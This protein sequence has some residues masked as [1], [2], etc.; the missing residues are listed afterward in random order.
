MLMSSHTSTYAYWLGLSDMRQEGTWEWQSS[1]T[2]ASYVNWFPENPHHD[3][4]SN[5][6][7]I[8]MDM[9]MDGNIGLWY[10]IH[11]ERDT[12]GWGIYAIC[13]APQFGAK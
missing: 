4:Q 2:A 11:C 6:A 9:D 8:T 1:F 13:E 5:C 12:Y 10:D 3:I 7:Q